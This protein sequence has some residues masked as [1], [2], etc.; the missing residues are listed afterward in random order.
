MGLFVPI[1]MG[2][3]AVVIAKFRARNNWIIGAIDVIILRKNVVVLANFQ[4]LLPIS[5]LEI[6]I[7][8]ANPLRAS[9]C[10]CQNRHIFVLGCYCTLQRVT[11]VTLEPFELQK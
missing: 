1:F 10:L 9:Y 3:F 2:K 8:C 7:I 5:W 4:L 6:W 11:L